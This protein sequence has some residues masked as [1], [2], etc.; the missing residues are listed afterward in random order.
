ME[1]KYLKVKKEHHIA[2]VTL[3][4]P[5]KLN[6]LSIDL[7]QEIINVA[8]AFQTDDESR[9]VVFCG[10]GKLFSAG[11]DLSDP[12]IAEIMSHNSLL[13]KSRLPRLG[14]RMIRAIY[15]MNQITLA[16]VNGAAYG[17][18]ACIATACDFRIGAEG[19]KIGYPEVNLGMN[20]SWGALPLVLNL[21]G[22]SRAKRMV[23]LGEKLDEKTLLNWGFLDQVVP[24]EALMK[25]ALKM[26]EQYAVQPPIAAQMIKRS[27]NVLVAATDQTTM[28]MDADQYLLAVSTEDF[29]EGIQAFFQKREPHFKGN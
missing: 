9:V 27:L 12:K 7:M 23:I 18:G 29:S 22:L 10:A 26:A 19:C 8:E 5:D 1:Y 20:L 6:A 15:E 14:R 16:A 28:H 24:A 3:N 25:T 17:G 4:R 13:I 21:I 11:A 2:T